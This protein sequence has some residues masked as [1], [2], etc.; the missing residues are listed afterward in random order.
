M[1]AYCSAV[2]ETTSFTPCE[3]IFRRQVDLPIDLQ[4]GRPEQENGDQKETEYVHCLQ[5]RSDRV[6]AFARGNMKLGS[7][8][9][10]RYYDHKAQN[11]GFERGD[12][13]W[14]H[15][16]RCKKGRTLK[17]QRPWKDCT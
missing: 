17:L 4:L 5:A 11:R 7:K 10:K 13:I 1:M 2:H 15:N 14:L 6:H 16:P 3:L 12:P 9:H 8:R